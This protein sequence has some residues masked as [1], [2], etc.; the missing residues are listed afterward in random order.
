MAAVVG[1][2]A[3]LRRPDSYRSI[4]LILKNSQSYQAS[5]KIAFAELRITKAITAGAKAA[6][7]LRDLYVTAEAVTFQNILKQAFFSKL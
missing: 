6:L 5:C 4:L 7:I 1:V 3:R 2:R